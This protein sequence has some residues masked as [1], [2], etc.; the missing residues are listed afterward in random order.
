M[1]ADLLA[2]FIHVYS[3]PVS[4]LAG[5]LTDHVASSLTTCLF[6]AQIFV[7]EKV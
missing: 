3:L 7:S 2:T 5:K 6:D 4:K 1:I